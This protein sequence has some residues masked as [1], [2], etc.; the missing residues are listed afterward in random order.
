MKPTE[1][2]Q[3]LA[4][5][6]A[7][8]PGMTIPDGTPDVWHELLKDLDFEAARQAVFA[9]ARIS[10]AIITPADIRK[11]AALLRER[12]APRLAIDPGQIRQTTPPPEW[13]DLK[14]KLAARPRKERESF[15]SAMAALAAK[16]DQGEV[17]S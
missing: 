2:V 5:A 7:T 9:H 10:S 13:F 15:G 11:Q 16:L 17:S 3:I 8:Y 12:T 14:Q 6:F 4:L 1:S